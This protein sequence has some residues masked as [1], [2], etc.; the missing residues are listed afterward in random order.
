MASYRSFSG[1]KAIKESLIN[2]EKNIGLA[3]LSRSSSKNNMKNGHIVNLF[4]RYPGNPILSTAQ[5][6]YAANT[7]FNAGACRLQGS[8]ETLLLVRVEDRRGISHLTVARSKDGF[9]D[10]VIG[11]SPSM[12]PDE[13]EESDEIWGIED[14]R[15]VYLP[16]ME[17]YSIAYT[18]YCPTGPHVK[19]AL[20]KDFEEYQKIGSV[21]PPEDK[22]ASLF[23]RRFDERWVMIH[24]P[25]SSFTGSADMWISFSPDLQHWGDH[26]VMMQARSG[27]WWDA[28]KIGLSPPPIETKEGWIILYHGVRQTPAGALYRLGA[29]LCDLED[30]A[31]VIRRGKEWIFGPEEEY[32]R[33]GDVSD[34]VFPCGYT[35]AEDG[36]TIRLYYGAADTCMAV[37]IGS[38]TEVLDWLETQV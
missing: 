1:R 15:I 38:I 18:A 3:G 20:T 21:Q 12:M 30:P 10:W 9:R 25:V 24:R 7:I 19:L 27:A 29:A 6:P 5:W 13:S 31:K 28:R 26:K 34:V 2:T 17:M 35:I 8:G 4:K 32:E 11:S 37:A 16:E 36:D 33:V 23:P 22:D 14:P